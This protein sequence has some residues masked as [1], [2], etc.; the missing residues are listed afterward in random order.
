[1]I[2]Q[3]ID[4]RYRVQELLGQGGVGEVFRAL[5]TQTQLEVAVK[6]LKEDLLADESM[7]LSF[8]YEY[9]RLARLSHPNIL[10]AH[11][12]G[13]WHN[14]PFFTM[15]L[16]S[17]TDLD[18]WPDLQAHLLPLL[19][20]V[21]DALTYLHGR[22]FVHRD[23]KP[24]N[25][26]VASGGT[27]QVRM[28]DFGLLVPTGTHLRHRLAGTPQ[29][30]SPEAIAG[31]RVDHRADLYSLG[32]MMY[33][34]ASGRFPRAVRR[35]G[36]QI[37]VDWSQAVPP[38]SGNF[39]PDFNRMVL[40]L[41]NPHPAGRPA[42]TNDVLQRLQ[43]ICGLSATPLELT[44]TPPLRALDLIGRDHECQ[45]IADLIT[46]PRERGARLVA[47]T[48]ERG[49]G[50]TRLLEQAVLHAKSLARR[51]ICVNLSPSGAYPLSLLRE[52]IEP[53]AD[54]PSLPS[55]LR[56]VLDGGA[57]NTRV[58]PG[59]AISPDQHRQ[60]EG[61]CRAICDW[62]PSP[63]TWSQI[64][65]CVDDVHHADEASLTLLGLLCDPRTNWDGQMIIALD[66]AH[67]GHNQ[68]GLDRLT[69]RAIP[70]AMREFSVEMVTEM[71]RAIF[72]EIPIPPPFSLWLTTQTR[73]NP[74]RVEQ[75]LTHLV[76]R[77]LIRHAQG[78]WYVPLDG[79]QSDH[80]IDEVTLG[81][82][83]LEARARQICDVAAMLNPQSLSLLDLLALTLLPSGILI[84]E[85]NSLVD[86]AVL[87]E[88]GS[89]FSFRDTR[90][91]EARY[92]QIA[93]DRRRELHDRCAEW[94][95]SQPMGPQERAS[96]LGYHLARS[97]EPLQAVTHLIEAG[98]LAY[99]TFSLRDAI[100]PLQD[101]E[102]ILL[103][104]QP[105]DPR[106][107]Q[108]W[109]MLARI[110][111]ICD[112]ELARSYFE[113]LHRNLLGHPMIRWFNRL[114]RVLP[115]MIAISLTGIGRWL[116]SL[117]RLRPL[118]ME[119]LSM[120]IRDFAIA[121][122]FLGSIHAIQGRGALALRYA[123]EIRGFVLSKRFVP[124]ASFHVCRGLA[125]LSRG[126][127]GELD[128]MVQARQVYERDFKT[129]IDPIDRMMGLATCDLVL[130]MRAALGGIG[131]YHEP[132]ARL[133]TLATESD[134]DLLWAFMHQ[135]EQGVAA[136][137]GRWP[138]AITAQEKL[139]QYFKRSGVMWPFVNT[140]L[141]FA[142]INHYYAGMLAE[143]RLVVDDL[144]NS[145]YGEFYRIAWATFHDGVILGLEGNATAAIDH[146]S[147]AL[148]WAEFDEYQNYH[149]ASLCHFE[150]TK[151]HLTLRDENR[152]RI[153][154]AKAREIC[155]AP[156]TQNAFL[157]TFCL[158]TEGEL[159]L[160]FNQRERALSH[161]QRVVQINLK[162]PRR[163]N[164]IM[165]AQA[166]IGLIRA[167]APADSVA[168]RQHIQ[169]A[170][171]LIARIGNHRL[172][173]QLYEITHSLDEEM[174]HEELDQ[175]IETFIDRR[176]ERERLPSMEVLLRAALHATP[177]W[178]EV[179]L[180]RL[181][182]LAPQLG[183]AYWSQTR[184]GLSCLA[185][186]G[187][188]R[189]A[190]EA[191]EAL[192]L[193]LR[194]HPNQLETVRAGDMLGIPLWAL[195][196]DQFVFVGAVVCSD[197]CDTLSGQDL[198]ALENVVLSVGQVLS[199]TRQFAQ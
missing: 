170:Q 73:G 21:T 175:S 129:P 3:V 66:G 25:F 88:D 122:A 96:R 120:P 19:V 152:A 162:R 54:D 68:T 60:L 61:I 58:A 158:L 43:Q 153:H 165:L 157:M 26:R 59:E 98:S 12:F 65:F 7:R 56:D 14:R 91:G 90:T 156:D 119:Q 84:P 93:P 100:N 71:L 164:P 184:R 55:S 125:L 133:R 194:V 8:Q 198:R 36:T 139:F 92:L 105:D 5:D 4:N 31:Q 145:A 117:L 141:M 1:M 178:I 177:D 167:S 79:W 62:T 103:N 134:S 173:R 29:Y 48:G 144:R 53:L 109:K 102:I 108:V 35:E 182:G 18:T 118:D 74:N 174:R 172:M 163:I 151:Q 95:A 86:R 49:I 113:K 126:V 11:E 15:E 160:V 67:A 63:A 176:R 137:E 40:E 128:H 46:D 76:D 20:Q 44:N 75:V 30:M 181:H 146:L 32:V 197:A 69:Q 159:D 161:F 171:E 27:P 136:M 132:L 82:P 193:S 57:G 10:S 112:A 196:G 116:W 143:A 166:H 64:V 183:I 45:K 185:R 124:W 17:G 130:G 37:L 154:L 150:L 179:M 187:D 168:V 191:E 169:Q 142:A 115:A 155:S 80:L 149:M 114:K 188:N 121:S 97:S 135:V 22:N 127:F 99:G 81:F 24:P 34:L 38:L 70:I 123:E 199:D 28:M 50:K 51:V 23:I 9:H 42:R 41:L 72:G 192:A 138:D 33:H 47:I 147:R 190:A 186:R 39:P 110:G 16:V 13:V 87:V 111:S 180:A 140:C 85:L 6:L 104:H 101:A 106:R 78:R 148:R 189:V 77:E 83:H 94:L 131:D 89:R 52:L 195:D 107:Q 2:D